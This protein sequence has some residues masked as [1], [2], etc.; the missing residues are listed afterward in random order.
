MVPGLRLIEQGGRIGLVR[1][2]S[3]QAIEV[4][5][6]MKALIA[7]ALE[8]ER[9]SRSELTSAFAGQGSA[10]VERFLTESTRMG[11]L[12]IELPGG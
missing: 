9:F 3:R 2:G 6:E 11:I 12:E 5:A 4:P 7:W 10:V 1:A 8:R